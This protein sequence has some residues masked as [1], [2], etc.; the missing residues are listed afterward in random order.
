VNKTTGGAFAA[1]PVFCCQA[2]LQ[3][4]RTLF[5]S[6]PAGLGGTAAASD[7]VDMRLQIEQGCR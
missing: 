3:R 6:D 7:I 2:G 4:Q 1:P 5:V